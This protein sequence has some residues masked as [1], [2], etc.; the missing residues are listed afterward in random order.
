MFQEV[1][2]I[3]PLNL[4]LVYFRGFNECRASEWTSDSA[5]L[6]QLMTRIHCAS[7]VT[8]LERV[9]SHTLNEAAKAPIGA[10]VFIGDAMEENPDRLVSSARKL[11]EAKIPSFLFQEGQDPNV[12]RVFRDL[13]SVSGGAYARFD[14]GAARQLA[15]LLKAAALYAVGGVAALTGRADAGSVLLLEQLG[16]RQ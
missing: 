5:R 3:G 1:A 10:L 9:L 11:G 13:A 8:Q 6:V 12:E 15:E 2:S 7:G 4:Q 16:K 14:A